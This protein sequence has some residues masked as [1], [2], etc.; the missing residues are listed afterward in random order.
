MK[1]QTS[2]IEVIDNITM[3]KIIVINLRRDTVQDHEN[4]IT[5]RHD[6]TRLYFAHVCLHSL[7]LQQ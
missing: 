3:K 4:I 2:H 5:E 1:V 7:F 6:P